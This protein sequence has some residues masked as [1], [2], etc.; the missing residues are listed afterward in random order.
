MSRSRAILFLLVGL[1]LAKTSFDHWYRDKGD[2]AWW[3]IVNMDGR[4]YYA[5]LPGVFIHQDPTYQFHLFYNAQQ[6]PNINFTHEL[7]DGSRVNKYF[8]GEAVL[9]TPFFLLS[10]ALALLLGFETHGYSIAHYF[11]VAFG[12]VFYVSVGLYF[13]SRVLHRHVKVFWIS[14]FV[15][16]A[17]LLGSNLFYYTVYE[18]SMSHAYSFFLVSSFLFVLESLVSKSSVYKLMVL[19]ILIGLIGITRPVNLIIL[20]MIPFA[21]V[22][23]HRLPT[24]TLGSVFGTTA[25][26][27]FWTAA[28]VS[29]QLAAYYWQ[30]GEWLVYSYKDE[31]FNW[32]DPQIFNTLFSYKRG[33][34]VYAP[35]CFISLF[36]AFK[37][38]K[39]SSVKALSLISTLLIAI[40]VVSSWH[41]WE[42]GWA[43][44]LRAYVEYLPL[45]GILLAS[46]LFRS[47]PIFKLGIL[48]AAV[49]CVIYTQIQTEQV[50]RSVLPLAGVEKEEFWNIFLQ[51]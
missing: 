2:S 31:G 6:D 38:W 30:T 9:L 11:S 37:L 7:T 14:V 35:L 1:F 39:G 44:G 28:V 25:I 32:S 34:F 16:I 22:R 40:Y 46:L 49:I 51:L 15:P 10:H 12:A 3:Y 19:G 33:L 20:G 42:Y 21:L 17:I 29:I 41:A 24:S 4:G 36:G 23:S 13:L 47:K 48:S 50:I 27:A 45:F 18:P 43:Y 26:V 5:Y 8:I